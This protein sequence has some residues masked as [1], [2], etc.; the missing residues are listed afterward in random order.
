MSA[1][2]DYEYA[3]REDHADDWQRHY[4]RL[5]LIA[6]DLPDGFSVLDAMH[7]RMLTESAERGLA[8]A[9]HK[10]FNEDV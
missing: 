7:L 4:D 10:L 8:T 3:L 5:H 2:R 9:Q 1:I 6:N